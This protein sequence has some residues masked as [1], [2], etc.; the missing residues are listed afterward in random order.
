MKAGLIKFDIPMSCTLR[1][2]V[3][4]GYDHDA[5]TE[6]VKAAQRRAFAAHQEVIVEYVEAK[7]AEWVQQVLDTASGEV[8]NRDRRIKELER[9]LDTVKHR[10][11]R[12]EG[13]VEQLRAER[14]QI[15]QRL[16]AGESLAK[17]VAELEQLRPIV[18]A[19]REVI[20][21]G[22]IDDPEPEF[23]LLRELVRMLDAP[24]E[25]L[26]SAGDA[27]AQTA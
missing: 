16:A 7:Q 15:G 2:P 19:A 13:D 22:M 5:L 1:V 9:D 10:A 4:E 11:C 26:E 27:E 25:A 18:S 20:R 21:T 3:L 12:L 24:A 17:A 14:D 6:E 23:T 8:Q